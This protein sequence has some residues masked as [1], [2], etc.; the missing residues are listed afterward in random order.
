M[1]PQEPARAMRRCGERA[2]D[3]RMRSPRCAGSGLGRGFLRWDSE[4]GGRALRGM[5]RGE[6]YPE[7]HG[8]CAERR[9]EKVPDDS[10]RHDSHESVHRKLF[11]TP[12]STREIYSPRIAVVWRREERRGLGAPQWAAVVVSRSG[13]LDAKT[14]SLRYAASCI[15]VDDD[16]PGN[17]S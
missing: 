14:I 13:H 7:R 8:H 4:Q 15:R 9:I 11:S 12:P 17:M 3:W 1:P 10:A 16:A 2:D 6:K 5:M